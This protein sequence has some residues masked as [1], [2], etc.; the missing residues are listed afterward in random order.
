V[1]SDR[2]GAG[3]VNQRCRTDGQTAARAVALHSGAI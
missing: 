2:D 3:R 1:G